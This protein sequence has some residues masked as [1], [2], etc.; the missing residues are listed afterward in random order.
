MKL[1]ARTSL[2]HDVLASLRPVVP[3]RTT[4]PVLDNVY[5][6]ASG[7][8]AFLSATDLDQGIRRRLPAVVEHPGETTIPARRFM[9][10]LR[11]SEADEVSL[12]VK[13][14]GNRLRVGTA[15]FDLA[16]VDP[17][18]F[19]TLPHRSPH[20]DEAREIGRL[21]AGTFRAMVDAVGDLTATRDDEGRPALQ[22]V[23]LHRDGHHL[24]LVATDGHRLG[25][26]RVSVS[27]DAF[28]DPGAVVQ[29]AAYQNFLRIVDPDTE[30][31]FSRVGEHFLLEANGDECSVRGVGQ[32]YP[33]YTRVIPGD[34]PRLA[35]LDRDEFLAALRR[36][37][38]LVD[39]PP[40]RVDLEFSRDRVDLK[41][42]TPDLG[43]GNDAC[44]CDYSGDGGSFT[45]GVNAVYLIQ[46]LKKI[47][48]SRV[49]LRMGASER[50]VLLR[51][52]DAAGDGEADFL[53]LIMPLRAPS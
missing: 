16:R 39:K 44:G 5:I 4:L 8:E 50:A 6:E 49:E 41:V 24:V 15:R 1:S 36:S 45:I 17:E 37:Q 48:G 9:E 22:G 11:H 29:P 26:V 47:D 14:G 30:V 20:G 53:G 10:I 35:V 51:S 31:C 18:D 7:D 34:H 43:T 38:V 42:A 23:Y 3:T 27:E 32:E 12:E 46:M 19:P 28:R 52:A 33:D 2:L 21:R 13:E 40:H 25:R